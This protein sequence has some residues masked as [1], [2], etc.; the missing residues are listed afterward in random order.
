MLQRS[1]ARP[2]RRGIPKL[3]SSAITYKQKRAVRAKGH[4]DALCVQGQFGARLAGGDLPEPNI[5]LPTATYPHLFA[6]RGERATRVREPSPKHL[7]QCVQP[8]RD[9]CEVGP[10]DAGELR[11]LGLLG[12]FETA[13]QPQQSAAAFALLG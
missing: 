9:G 6:V 2:V 3:G 1:V 13:C 5:L 10:D 11:V 7:A 4:C 12:E 8:A